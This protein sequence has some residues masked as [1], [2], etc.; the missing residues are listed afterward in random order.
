MWK[1]I[2]AFG[3]RYE[4]SERGEIRH[5]L[6]KNVRKAR[7]NKYGYLQLNFSKNDGTGKSDTILIHRL[8]A[9]TFIPNPNNLPEVNHID[10]NKQNNHVSNLE[11]CSYSENGKHSH[12]IGLQQAQKGETHVGAKL[13][14][15][16]AKRIRQLYKE[17]ISQQ[18]LADFFNVSQITISRI[19]RGERYN[20]N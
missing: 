18:K 10:G 7:I 15:D 11:W 9:M 17:G 14:N 20:G 6:N 16:Q 1:V 8:I 2:P 3:G 12:K 5:S 13:T 4:A 19:V